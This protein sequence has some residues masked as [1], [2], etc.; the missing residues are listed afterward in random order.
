MGNF[1]AADTHLRG[2]YSCVDM[3]NTREWE[4]RLYGMTQRMILL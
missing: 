4:Y 1:E 2:F 3:N